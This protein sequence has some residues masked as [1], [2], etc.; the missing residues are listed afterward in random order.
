MRQRCSDD[1][2]DQ[3]VDETLAAKGG[4]MTCTLARFA[5]AAGQIVVA[6]QAPEPS[7]NRARQTLH[8]ARPT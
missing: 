6:L 4:A 8:A 5:W 7:S 3:I 2:G 1:I